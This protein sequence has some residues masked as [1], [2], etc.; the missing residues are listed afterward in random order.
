M[1]QLICPLTTCRTENAIVAEA[2][3]RCGSPLS[4]YKKLSIYPAQL[5]NQGLEVARQG[6]VK[7]ARDLFASVVYWCPNDKE[8]RNA[9]A[10][11]CFALYDFVEAHRHWEEILMQTPQDTIAMQGI[12]AL[13]VVHLKDQKGQADNAI[14]RA[15]NKLRPSRLRKLRVV[16]K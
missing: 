5:F 10:L 3:I 16:K 7:Q 9:L 14:K 13:K 4:T 11:A 15:R 2:C 1:K 12:E 6:Q 8:A